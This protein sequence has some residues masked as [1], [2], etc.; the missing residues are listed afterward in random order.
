MT[1][2]KELSTNGHTGETDGFHNLFDVAAEEMSIATLIEGKKHEIASELMV[3]HCFRHQMTGN[4]IPYH[5]TSAVVAAAHCLC[6]QLT[7]IFR[8]CCCG[9]T[10][11]GRAY[12]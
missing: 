9:T 4:H 11:I 2:R 8:C 5:C 6:Q 12:G 3:S 7:V 1:G 10:G